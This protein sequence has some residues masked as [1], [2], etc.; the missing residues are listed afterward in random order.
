[1]KKLS[2]ILI[3]LKDQSGRLL[4]GAAVGV[5]RDME[6]RLKALVQANV[7]VVVVDT[8]HGHSKGVMEA[9]YRIKERYP[10]LQ[11]IAGNVAT[12]EATRDLDQGRS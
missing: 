12:A 1:L 8:A 7:D 10:E 3:L 2:N 9:V 6:D 11:V 5:T 4:A